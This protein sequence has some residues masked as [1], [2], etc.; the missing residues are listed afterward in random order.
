MIYFPI[1]EDIVIRLLEERHAKELFALTDA[2]RKSLREWLPWVD[3]TKNVADTRNFIRASL[4][5]YAGNDGFQCGIWFRGELAGTVGFHLFDWRNRRTSI[6]YWLGGAY[7][8]HGLM[9]KAVRVLTDY[10]LTEIHLN[11]VEIRCATGNKKSC[12]IPERLGFTREGTLRE[13][14]WLYDHFV[15]HHV[16]SMLRSDWL[17]VKNRGRSR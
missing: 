1:G 14:E 11:R 9:T 4:N 12:A 3:D 8:G 15:D 2:N 7:R 6:G 16:Y 10:A 5:Q 13:T 17:R